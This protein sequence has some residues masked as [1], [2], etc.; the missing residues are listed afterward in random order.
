M[1]LNTPATSPIPISLLTGF[2]GSGKTT[3]LARALQAGVLVDTAILI[4]E[5]GEIGIDQQLMPMALVS[6]TLL[7]GGCVC[8][9][10]RG[11]LNA[12]LEDLYWARLERRIARFDRVV[13]ETTGIANPMPLVATLSAPGIVAERYRLSNILCTVDASQ[14]LAQLDRHPESR[15]QIA[16]ADQLVITKSDLVA[17]SVIE[18]LRDRLQ[19]SNPAARI[20]AR[21]ADD[22]PFAEWFTDASSVVQWPTGART[23]TTSVS[24]FGVESARPERQTPDLS[25]TDPSN[26]D[27]SNTERTSTERSSTERSSTERS[28]TE[29]SSTERSSPGFV[30]RP[31]GPVSPGRAFSHRSIATFSLRMAEPVAKGPLEAALQNLLDRFPGQILRVK[32]IVQAGDGYGV[33]QVA[34]DRVY[35][36]EPWAGAASDIPAEPGS[37]VVFITEGVSRDAVIALL[38]HAGI[39]VPA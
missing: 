15:A 14:G 23:S 25:N 38:R 26:T 12:A 4:N 32:G 24:R 6:P 33:L 28:S 10:V 7:A 31:I 21:S 30:A 2:L 5:L 1:A 37:T 9:T 16:L 39:R 35:R 17:G 11:D 18:A 13:I 29:Q 22:A 19:Q 27:P 34:G 36:I 3:L 8:C 20:M